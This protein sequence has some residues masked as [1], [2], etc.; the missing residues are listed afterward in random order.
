MSSVRVSCNCVTV[1][2][3]HE[4]SSRMY[5]YVIV[6]H[7]GFYLCVYHTYKSHLNCVEFQCQH[8]K[9]KQ[10]WASSQALWGHY[11]I[12]QNYRILLLLHSFKKDV[13]GKVWQAYIRW[14]ISDLRYTVSLFLWQIHTHAHTL[15]WNV[16][17]LVYFSHSLAV[18]LV[19]MTVKMVMR[20]C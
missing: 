3:M 13:P 17:Q 1:E 14:K 5:S 15:T 6:I 7:A 18:M 20:N 16:E 8:C 2:L 12:N 19:R 4:R 11:L 10:C 9:Q